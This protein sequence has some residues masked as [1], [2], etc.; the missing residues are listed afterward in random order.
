M[1]R[2]CRCFAWGWACEQALGWTEQL[3]PSSPA[4]LRYAG[5]HRL[6]SSVPTCLQSSV[7]MTIYTVFVMFAFALYP[8]FS[9]LAFHAVI[10]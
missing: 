2:R 7:K 3:V 5:R 10:N 1:P 4:R 8:F 6:P 9:S